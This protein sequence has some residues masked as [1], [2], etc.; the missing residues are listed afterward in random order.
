MGRNTVFVH[1]LYCPINIVGT[2][3]KGIAKLYITKNPNSKRFYLSKIEKVSSDARGYSAEYGISPR[4]VKPTPND[5]NISVAEIYAF[6][7]EHDVDYEKDSK[8]PVYFKPN[9][10]SKIVNNDGIIAA[11]HM[12]KVDNRMRINKL[13]SVYG[14][15]GA[16]KFVTEQFKLGNVKYLD[17]T[18]SQAW[19]T[20]RGLQL[21]KLVQSNPD[22]N[23]ILQK[24]DIVKIY[25]A[26]KHKS[27]DKFR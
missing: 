17:K 5:T 27:D 10:P 20:S 1:H 4:G 26:K 23:N 7:K 13:A 21:P 11:I 6:V 12:N 3:Q 19:S 25:Y 16:R 18:K 15:D 24:E 9:Q 8:N 14:K 22:N 2:N